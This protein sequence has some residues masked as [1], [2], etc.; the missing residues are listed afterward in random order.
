MLLKPC[1]LKAVKVQNFTCSVLKSKL[2]VQELLV[3]V[4]KTSC[5]SALGLPNI[6]KLQ[7]FS[8]FLIL[9]S[10]AL[11]K[12]S[13]ESSLGR[14]CWIPERDPSWHIVER[15]LREWHVG[16]E[17][18]WDDRTQWCLEWWMGWSHSVAPWIMVYD[19]LWGN[20]NNIYILYSI[21][22]YC[23]RIQCPCPSM[24]GL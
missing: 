3:S 10:W 23:N 24:P 11:A 14:R 9:E 19:H 6:H 20:A 22:F 18:Q 8:R 7:C 17:G 4:C 13:L 15:H 5:S 1:S 21:D 2:W 16:G 12:N